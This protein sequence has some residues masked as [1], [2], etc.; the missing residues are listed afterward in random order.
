MKGTAVYS[1]FIPARTKEEAR[2]KA[3]KK[4]MKL[5]GQWLVEEQE[6]TDNEMGAILQ[7]LARLN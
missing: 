3:E 5:T 4:G 1:C 7:M 6:I 2:V